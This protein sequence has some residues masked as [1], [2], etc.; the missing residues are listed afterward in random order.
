MNIFFTIL[1]MKIIKTMTIDFEYGQLNF[2]SKTRNNRQFINHKYMLSF[3][4]LFF[5]FFNVS[6][7]IF[8]DFLFVKY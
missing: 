3:I 8:I 1:L 6:S 7:I 4:H 5:Y 2:K